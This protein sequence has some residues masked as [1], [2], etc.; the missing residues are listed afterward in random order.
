VS[1]WDK[2]RVE[3]ADRADVGVAVFR[4]SGV[5][6]SGPETYAFLEQVQFEAHKGPARIV[7]DLRGVTM[8]TSAGVGIIAA[9]FTSVSN[10]G[11]KLCIA[12]VAGRAQTILN[13]VRLLDVVASA[14]DEDAAVKVVTA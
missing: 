14:P 10:S 6:D 5:L 9:C 11:G 7:L 1:K 2:L 4:L 3:R 12:S 13:V 8:M